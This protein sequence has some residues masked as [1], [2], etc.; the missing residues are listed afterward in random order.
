[1]N[2]ITTKQLTHVFALSVAFAIIFSMY[3]GNII[4]EKVS[5]AIDGIQYLL[6]PQNNFYGSHTSPYFY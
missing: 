4:E 2:I 1:M 3:C 5:D 6:T